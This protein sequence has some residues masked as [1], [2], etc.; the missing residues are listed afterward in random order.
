MLM[1]SNELP[2]PYGWYALSFSDELAVGEVKPVRYFG[3]D[4]VLYRSESGRAVLLDAYCP[5]LGAH[6]GHGGSVVGESIACP[7]HG[8]QFNGEGMC[9]SVPYAKN[10]P[11]RAKDK[12]CIDG[13]PITETN[14]MI[15]AWY[16][17]RRIEPLFEVDVFPQMNELGWTDAHRY[18]WEINTCLQ[19]T[20]EN[21]VDIAHFVYVHTSEEMPR[22]EVELQDHRRVTTM[23]SRL[24]A[25]DESGA[26]DT[27]GAH[28]EETRLVSTSSGPGITGQS[29]E[30]MFTAFM[31]GALTP[32]EPGKVKMVWT[33]SQPEEQD[34]VQQL[35]FE[36][37]IKHI[38]DEVGN[39]IPIWENKMYQ[40][41]PILCDGDGPIA[42]YRKW[43]S[44]FYDEGVED[45]PVRLVK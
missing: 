36:G 19:E 22:A 7:F 39:D 9:T 18:E 45:A 32:I 29:F 37:M 24:R 20:G 40:S 21:A 8:W 15:W 10:I 23:I 42:K 28:W 30:R 27:T 2:I 12:P 43:F 25:L 35:Y 5:H 33:F 13:Y 6:L 38:V 11:P 14:R 4:L 34:E 44:Q 31:V 3:K 26:P 16:H 41:D 17:P 1:R